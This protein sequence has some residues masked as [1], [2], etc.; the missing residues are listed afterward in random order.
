MPTHSGPVRT[1]VAAGEPTADLGGGIRTYPSRCPSGFGRLAG[2]GR[3][4][5]LD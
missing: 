3:R 1:S 2:G 5:K 4:E